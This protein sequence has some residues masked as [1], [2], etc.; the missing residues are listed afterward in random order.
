MTFCRSR[1]VLRFALFS[2][3]ATGLTTAA[4][5]Q[6]LPKTVVPEHY[7]LALTPDLKAAT[8]AGDEIIDVTLTA[9][10]K[11]ITLN[12]AE[13]TFKSVTATPVQGAAETA[14]VSLDPD[15]EQ[16]TLT[17][18]AELPAGKVKLAIAY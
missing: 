7:T 4:V 17:F 16:A 18:P 15:K 9:S 6:R 14:T 13:I 3:F 8:F 12:A 1:K 5:A 10:S 11:T 2:A